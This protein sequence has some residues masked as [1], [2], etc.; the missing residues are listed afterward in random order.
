[1]PRPPRSNSLKYV[2]VLGV[3][4][5]GGWR[6]GVAAYDVLAPADA[7]GRGEPM[8]LG[9]ERRPGAAP[10][11]VPIDGSNLPRSIED[12]SQADDDGRRV[13]ELAESMQ[14]LVRDLEKRDDKRDDFQNWSASVAKLPGDLGEMGPSLKLGLDTARNN[15]MA[16]C[17][18]GLKGDA[19]AAGKTLATDFVL[20]LE[21]RDGAVDVVG[22]KEARP[23]ALP[24]SVRDCCLEVLRGLEVRVYFS[25]PGQRY[26]YIYEIEA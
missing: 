3:M 25:T 22:A 4:V 1:M 9:V 26:A 6:L 10:R 15:D 19:G 23:G 14:R 18:R 17:F 7:K 13:R 8:I 21:T 24:P 11:F 16:F 5:A 2:L 12:A 20:Y